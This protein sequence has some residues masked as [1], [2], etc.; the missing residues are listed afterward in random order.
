MV[1]II[2]KFTQTDIQKYMQKH[3]DN[4]CVMLKDVK[5]AQW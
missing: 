4:D 1:I 2:I 3:E 5:G